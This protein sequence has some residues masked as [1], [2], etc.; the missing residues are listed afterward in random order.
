MLEE[1]IGFVGGGQMATA[2]AAGF[3]S[4]ELTEASRLVVFDPSEEAKGRF[5]EK[6]PGTNFAKDVCELTKKC[7][8]IFLA[9]KP[10]YIFTVA[11]EIREANV[12]TAPLVVSI[13]AGISLHALEEQLGMGRVIRVMP[14][15]PALVGQG[16]AAFA[17]GSEAVPAD[18]AIVKQLLEAV[19]VALEL[20]ESQLDA[21]TGL[22]GSGPAFVYLMIEAMS[23]AGVRM[24]LPRDVAAKLSTQT[25]LG[26]ASMVQA[27]GLHPAVLKDQVTS[28]G[29]TTIAGLQKLEDHG[30]RSALI[31][32]VEAAT[33]RARELGGK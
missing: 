26:A 15:T 20:P 29:G 10:Q 28:P 33:E 18:A 30:V 11:N 1:T 6:I 8:I 14:N 22:S 7:S 5:A 17:L 9:T 13:A 25:V 16:A 24:G 31:A 21:V 12:A 23:D 27:T 19:G 32:A 3:L 2:L 4:A